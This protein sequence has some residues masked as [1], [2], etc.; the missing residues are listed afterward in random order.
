VGAGVGN[1]TLP[2][3]ILSCKLTVPPDWLIQVPTLVWAPLSSPTIYREI[4]K[5]KFPVFSL[6]QRQT[7][8]KVTGQ[9]QR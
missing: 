7:F 6:L 4:L 1:G 3:K 2:S 5:N 9:P 8:K